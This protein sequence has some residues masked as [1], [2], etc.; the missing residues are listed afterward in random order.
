MIKDYYY[1]L[2]IKRSSSTQEIKSAYR[3]LAVK[4]HPDKN[5]GDKFFEERFKDIQ[6]AYEV[7]SHDLE[8]QQYDNQLRGNKTENFDESN[9]RRYE[10]ELKRKYAEELTKKEE[11]IK[12]KYQTSEQHAQEEV[13]KKKQAKEARKRAERQNV[14]D[15]IENIQTSVKRK[16]SKIAALNKE[17]NDL[18]HEL[19]EGR[20]RLSYLREKLDGGYVSPQS[21]MQDYPSLAVKPELF[22]ELDRIKAFI[23]YTDIDAFVGA[24]VKFIQNDRIDDE[25]RQRYPH[26]SKLIE[27]AAFDMTPLTELIEEHNS[28]EL[29]IV[30][31]VTELIK[32][33]QN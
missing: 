3:K 7:L 9:V 22:K 31:L 4:F 30:T 33:L 2:G 20:S 6:E 17:L 21:A 19:K 23:D 14:V 15:E 28:D 10:E 18:N 16:V 1:I 11:E 26:L 8:K 27:N 24:L 29:E 32:Y 13:E 12:R 5:D 25:Y